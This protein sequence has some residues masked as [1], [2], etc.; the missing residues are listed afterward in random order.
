MKTSLSLKIER[1]VSRSVEAIYLYSKILNQEENIMRILTKLFI[2][3]TSILVFQ[4]IIHSP[5]KYIT[6]PESVTDFMSCH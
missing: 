5:K 3:L 1:Q 6:V 4:T 2:V